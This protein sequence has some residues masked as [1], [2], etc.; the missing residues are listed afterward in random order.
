MSLRE[1][2]KQKVQ[3]KNIPPKVLPKYKREEVKIEKVETVK[4]PII[5]FQ[6]RFTHKK[7]Y[8]HN[9][10]PGKN[11][12]S[13]MLY[14]VEGYERNTAYEI[15]GVDETIHPEE[16]I[17]CH[18]YFC[19]NRLFKN[20]MYECEYCHNL[21]CSEHKEP[22]RPLAFP[23]GRT[24]RNASDDMIEYHKKGH[25]CTDYAQFIIRWERK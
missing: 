7:L 16:K 3:Q 19:D 12:Y 18:Y 14:P 24:D 20:E 6:E 23:G 15:P 1:R 25:P 17:E 5:G 22:K 4:R 11:Q 8:D 2:Y 9:Y 13:K 21:F 10:Y